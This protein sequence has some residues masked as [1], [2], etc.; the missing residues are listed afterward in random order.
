MFATD[1]FRQSAAIL[2][3][4]QGFEK[5]TGGL[6]ADSQKI[7]SSMSEMPWPIQQRKGI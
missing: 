2:G 7:V 6:L 1:V 4:I 3:L 5:A